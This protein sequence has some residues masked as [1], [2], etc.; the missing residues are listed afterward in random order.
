M[1]AQGFDARTD[2]DPLPDSLWSEPPDVAAI[3]AIALDRAMASVGAGEGDFD[4]LIATRDAFLS[5]VE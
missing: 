1:K 5:L 4:A 3:E 2:A